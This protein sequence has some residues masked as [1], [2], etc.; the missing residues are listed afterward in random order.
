VE[1]INTLQLRVYS[2]SM[3][4]M[5]LYILHLNLMAG[6]FRLGMSTISCFI[7]LLSLSAIPN[8]RFHDH[9]SSTIIHWREAYTL[10]TN[11]TPRNVAF[12]NAIL[13]VSWHVPSF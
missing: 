1:Q 4:L 2:K 12:W 6:S 7:R 13:C 3:L 8:F 10:Q 5:I 11:Q 9:D